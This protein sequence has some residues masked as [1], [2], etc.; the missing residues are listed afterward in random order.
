MK[1]INN[2]KLRS[3]Q[4]SIDRTYA[5]FVFALILSMFNGSELF[6]QTTWIGTTTNAT[7]ATNWN[8]GLPSTTNGAILNGTGGTVSSTLNFGNTD[9]SVTNLAVSNYSGDVTLTN[10][11]DFRLGAATASLVANGVAGSTLTINNS[12]TSITSTVLTPS[13]NVWSG[14]MNVFLNRFVTHGTA[15][16]T[17]TTSIGQ[18]TIN[19]FYIQGS[20][21]LAKQT[22]INSGTININTLSQKSNTVV[23]DPFMTT[24]SGG[25][26]NL[27]GT[28][29]STVSHGIR[30]SS[31]T[32]LNL[33]G[34][35]SL[36]TADLYVQGA[37]STN[38]LGLTSGSSSA[39]TLANNLIIT[40][41]T[42]GTVVNIV[43]GAGKSLALNGLISSPG[44]TTGTG[45]VSFGAGTISIAGTNSYNTRSQIVGGGKLEVAKLSTTT[46]SALG[47][48]GE[49]IAG[50]LTFDNGTLSY[51]GIGDTN[52]RN[53]TIGAGGARIE[54][55]G[56]GLLKMGS[57]GTI[58][59]SGSG[60][61]SLT[62]AGSN[63]AA[64]SFS[65]KVADGT[66]GITTVVKEGTGAW[67]VAA[68]GSTY[69]GG[70]EVRGGTLIS[71]DPN[72]SGFGTGEI[73]LYGGTT[74]KASGTTTRLF[75]NTF[76]T[77]GDIN[78]DW[79]QAQSAV[80]LA[81]DTKITATGTNSSG[82]STVTFNGA[83]GGAGG[84]TKSGAGSMTLSVTNG[85]TGATRLM[86]GS[87]LVAS[88]ASIASSSGTTVDG[89]LLNVNGTAGAVTVNT[90]GSL[91]GSG[92]VGA[93][94]LNSGAFLKPGN[95][96]GLLTASSATWAAGSTYNW[97]IDS[98][99]SSAVAGTNWDLFSVTGA[100]DMSALKLST[101]MNLVLNSLS[102][103][104]LASTTNRTWVIAQAGSLLGTGGTELAAGANVSDY[105]NI[106][107]TA[108][109]AGTPSLVSEW[110][111]EV[112]ET[113][114]TLNLMAIPEPSTG[115]LLGFG[116]GGLVVT[117]LL[118]RTGRRGR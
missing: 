113:G 53:F 115:A 43:P 55:N 26:V 95:S 96:P 20:T 106:N 13:G 5:A 21:N 114:K 40:N 49:V 107:A 85:Y 75:T 33:A 10:V 17:L 112:G 22:I 90:G 6:S 56:T 98:N 32:T 18:L 116:L 62:L 24:F 51:V 38:T 89:G 7:S 42:T 30:I 1:G 74:F 66:G 110:R 81:S 111:I 34:N 14:N 57:T 82:S 78:M 50:N 54:A 73:R 58:A 47:T 44:A 108:F 37:T 86:Q 4:F 93:L 52:S 23:A 27:L 39:V 80:N 109:N 46:G 65:L 101:Q 92:T 102:G 91:G 28:N 97:E 31:S 117:R 63:T 16:L 19:D 118:R 103:F 87:L 41:G 61:R 71:G 77:E 15:G 104:V 29:N 25:T 79:V 11:K 67:T 70:T 8:N 3:F 2:M 72:T 59:T 64:N 99:A 60:N 68:T 76:R 83:I 69:T 9:F 84:L 48:A 36:G 94:T 100:L 88:N 35:G 12:A 45:L 105:F